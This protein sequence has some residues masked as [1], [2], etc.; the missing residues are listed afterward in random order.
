MQGCVLSRDLREKTLLHVPGLPL[1]V[2]RG[3]VQGCQLLLEPAA[4]ADSATSA[5][6][7]ASAA[8][9]ASADSAASAGSA[10]RAPSIVS[11]LCAAS[12]ANAASATTCIRTVFVLK[13]FS[14]VEGIWIEG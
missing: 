1:R 10:S 11:A 9:D 6:S 2:L 12:A 8:S 3:L 4:S 5:A 14:I 13:L 7:S